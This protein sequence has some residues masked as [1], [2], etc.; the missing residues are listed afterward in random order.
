MSNGVLFWLCCAMVEDDDPTSKTHTKTHTK[1][2]KPFAKPTEDRHFIDANFLTADYGTRFYEA[3]PNIT[4]IRDRAVM[5]D[6]RG[7]PLPTRGIDETAPASQ[8]IKNITTEE[9]KA[10]YEDPKNWTL[11]YDDKHRTFRCD[12]TRFVN[13]KVL[14]GNHGPVSI[15][16]A[17][18]ARVTGFLAQN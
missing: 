12:P 8:R 9:F 14:L 4:N 15:D 18:Y 11:D 3:S 16:Y 1:T 7:P 6:P 17:D 13:R 5:L 10:L 2:P